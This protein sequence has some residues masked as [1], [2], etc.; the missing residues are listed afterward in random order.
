MTVRL[1]LDGTNPADR[2]A[3]T[4][5]EQAFRARGGT[6]DQKLPKAERRKDAAIKLAIGAI[7]TPKDD[8]P[9]PK[10]GEPDGRLRALKPEPCE[11]VLEVPEFE[12]LQGFYDSEDMQWLPHVCDVVEELS[13]RLVL[14]AKSAE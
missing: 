7:S 4:L 5:L 12:R 13:Q 10:P 6:R 3:F 1:A 14:A 11:L 8:G 9:E 2:F